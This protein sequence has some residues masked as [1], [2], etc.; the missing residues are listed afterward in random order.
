MQNMRVWRSRHG[1]STVFNSCYFM[2]YLRKGNPIN[3]PGY[4]TGSTWSVAGARR[5]TVALPL[6]LE[7]FQPCNGVLVSRRKGNIIQTSSSFEFR[8]VSSVQGPAASPSACAILTPELGGLSSGNP[9]SPH[10]SSVEQL[11]SGTTSTSSVS[12]NVPDD[13]FFSK[14]SVPEMTLHAI[15]KECSPQELEQLFYTSVVTRTVSNA[16]LK[17]F[18]S[19]LAPGQHTHALAAVNGAKRAGLRINATTFEVLIEHLIA[20]GQLKASLSLHQE[21]QRCH[22]IPTPRTYALLMDMCLDQGL[23]S[24][25]ESLFSDM[26]RKGI[27]P[28]IQNYELLLSAYAVHNPPKWEKAIALFDK[29]STQRHLRASAKTYSALMRVYL[30]M[31]PFDWRV[32]YNC[33]YEL[34]HHDPPI[35]LDWESYELVREALV[36][37]NA[38]W[39]RRLSTYCD[40][41]LTI[42]PM[43]TAQW[44]KGVLVYIVIMIAFKSIISS[45][46]SAF[47]TSANPGENLLDAMIG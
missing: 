6:T 40:A 9:A 20:S 12:P 1:Y 38:G 16:Q 33:Y 24:S 19:Q 18:L 27:R 42:T 46:F 2:R 31:R 39:F 28:S 26:S 30:N 13:H 41:W 36:K 43:F 5:G 7:R 22:L 8:Q 4:F 29:V 11:R 17:R 44:M 14:E 32:V 23:P 3:S 15:K 10:F 34:R 25:C 21:M 37:G 35:R 47:L 45:L